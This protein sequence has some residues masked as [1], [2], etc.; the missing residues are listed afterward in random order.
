MALRQR[1]STC[2]IL[3]GPDED[4]SRSWC[5]VHNDSQDEAAGAGSRIMTGFPGANVTPRQ[6]AGPYWVAACRHGDVAPDVLGRPLY[7]A[8]LAE[9]TVADSETPRQLAARGWRVRPGGEVICPQGCRATA[10]R[11]DCS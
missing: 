8:A 11:R 6:L 7:A 3:A 2:W 1:D 5:Y 9:F 4:I 10:N